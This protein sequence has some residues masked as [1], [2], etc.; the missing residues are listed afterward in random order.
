MHKGPCK[1]TATPGCEMKFFS[2]SHLASKFF[3]E[4][5]NSKKVVAI[6]KDKR[7]IFYAVSFLERPSKI[8]LGKRSLTCCKVDSRMD[9]I[10]RSRR[11]VIDRDACAAFFKQT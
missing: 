2:D 1:K 5:A 10:Q 4:V 8:K 7:N 11:V 3:K 9:D 6:F